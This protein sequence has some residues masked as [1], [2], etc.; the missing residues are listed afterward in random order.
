M[1]RSKFTDSQIMDALKRVDARLG[2]TCSGHK[3]GSRNTL[4]LLG[5][6]IDAVASEHSLFIE[7]ANYLLNRL[8]LA[9]MVG[10]LGESDL[11][12]INAYLK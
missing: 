3:V 1:K 7:Q 2:A 10:E 6:E 12:L 8:R 4:E 5:A 9:A 11:K